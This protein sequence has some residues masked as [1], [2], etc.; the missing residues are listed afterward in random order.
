MKYLGSKTISQHMLCILRHCSLRTTKD[1][2]FIHI[3]PNMKEVVCSHKVI[4]TV[5]GCPILSC[6]RV[7]EVYPDTLTRP[8][9][10]CK[11]VPIWALN[12]YV[13]SLFSIWVSHFLKSGAMSINTIVLGLLNMR[14][15]NNH[16]F[17][18]ANIDLILKFL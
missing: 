18:I 17:S 13:G 1:R 3:Y 15:S 6:S 14:I 12:K 2:R 7:K 9:V 4:I 5:E 10:S 8:A 16:Q 11:G